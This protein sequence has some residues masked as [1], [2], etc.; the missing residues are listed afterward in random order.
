[1]QHAVPFDKAYLSR[2]FPALLAK[3]AR[4]EEKHGC[5]VLFSCEPCGKRGGL[6]LELSRAVALGHKLY[7]RA[8]VLGGDTHPVVGA[9][10]QL[11][12]ELLDCGCYVRKVVQLRHGCFECHAA[13]TLTCSVAQKQ[14]AAAASFAHFELR[15]LAREIEST[16]I[17]VPLYLPAP[18]LLSSGT[19]LLHPATL[20]PLAKEQVTLAIN[21]GLV[22]YLGG[23]A[24]DAVQRKRLLGAALDKKVLHGDAGEQYQPL[25]VDATMAETVAAYALEHGGQR[26][27][28]DVARAHAARA[29]RARCLSLVELVLDAPAFAVL[30]QL[31]KQ[32]QTCKVQDRV[33]L[34]A[35]DLNRFSLESKVVDFDVRSLKL[36]RLL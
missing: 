29:C 32:T 19:P 33:E 17:K 14:R 18:E 3:L 24:G 9:H 7:S 15:R 28:P 27:A 23:R 2:A 35:L 4:S 16:A 22:R 6:S 31:V 30:E 11:I 1:V 25:V 36:R 8:K 12:A 13:T 5:Q 10:Y 34:L 20:K 26:L 21:G